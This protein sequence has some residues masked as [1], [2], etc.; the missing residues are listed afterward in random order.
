MLEIRQGV[1]VVAFGVKPE[2]E[3]FKCVTTALRKLC[4]KGDVKNLIH[5]NF[6]FH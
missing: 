6:P 2:L 1:K 3:S 5:E 4:Y